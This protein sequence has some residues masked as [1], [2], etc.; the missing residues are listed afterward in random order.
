M[1]TTF[2]RGCIVTAGWV[3]ASC[4]TNPPLM[5]GDTTTYGLRLGNDTAT[6]GGS[7]SLG[8]KAQSIA[9]VPVSVL[10][11][12]GKPRLLKGHGRHNAD[13]MSVFASFESAASTPA[14][15]DSTVRLG[16][17]FSTGVAAQV[18]T[19][20]YLCRESSDPSCARTAAAA[21]LEA[22]AAADKAAASAPAAAVSANST[23]ARLNA[24]LEGRPV[25][26][27]QADA[28]AAPPSDRPY[29]APLLFVRTDVVGIDIGGSLAEQGLQFNLGYT[30]R[31]LALIPVYA[32]GAGNTVVGITGGT[33]RTAEPSHDAMSV[34]GQFKV[35][36]ETARLGL[37]LNRYFAT[38]VAARNLG[39]SLG[40][41]IAKVPTPGPD[42]TVA[43]GLPGLPIASAAASAAAR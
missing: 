42:A 13:A 10:D 27:V 30:N 5:F 32:P 23:Q 35:N 12:N 41:A 6:G 16:Q 39:E 8:Y 34:L 4:S 26:I 21:A 17:V 24:A 14:S 37:G 31:N 25:T 22:A 38:G 15:N 43:L 36:T 1:K 3:L 19:M 9:V 11:E 40:A 20:G 7:V 29:Q 28:G 18:L 33:E 2:Q